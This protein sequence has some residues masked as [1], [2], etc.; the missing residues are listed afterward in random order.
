VRVGIAG[1]G[2]AAAFSWNLTL[3]EIGGSVEAVDAAQVVF[4]LLCGGV[5][6]TVVVSAVKRIVS[7]RLGEKVW[8]VCAILA[9]VLISTPVAL[10]SSIYM[11]AAL[12]FTYCFILLLNRGISGEKRRDKPARCNE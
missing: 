10:L 5:V 9:L 6:S 2:A 12:T 3:L 1:V 8:W 4:A 11:S 7:A